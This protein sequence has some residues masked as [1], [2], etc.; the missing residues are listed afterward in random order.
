MWGF[1]HQIEVELCSFPR[2]TQ[3]KK[4]NREETKTKQ[5]KHGVENTENNSQ[6]MTISKLR[7]D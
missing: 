7:K 1:L 4:L 3:S 2:K 6:K 5:E